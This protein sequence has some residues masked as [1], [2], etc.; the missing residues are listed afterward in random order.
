[1][2][3]EAALTLV[4]VHKTSG[5]EKVVEVESTLSTPIIVVNWRGC[6]AYA[7]NLEKNEL[8]GYGPLFGRRR[9]PT[10]WG[11]KDLG[12]AWDYWHERYAAWRERNPVR[13]RADRARQ[14]KYDRMRI[15]KT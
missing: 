6:G 4:L 15:R 8:F 9:T 11:A 12:A 1:M 7:L 5:E 3:G 14:Q 10:G 2:A 13:T